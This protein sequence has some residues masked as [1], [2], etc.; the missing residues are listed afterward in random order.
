MVA[1]DLTMAKAGRS[2]DVAGLLRCRDFDAR[3][4]KDDLVVGVITDLTDLVDLSS[5]EGMRE[6]FRAERNMLGCDINEAV[7]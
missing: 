4:E 3:T 5:A 1:N 7:S 2:R 6:L